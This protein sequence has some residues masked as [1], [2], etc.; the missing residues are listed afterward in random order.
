MMTSYNMARLGRWSNT[1]AGRLVSPFIRI[2][3]H[4]YT[5]AHKRTSFQAP[6]HIVQTEALT[7]RRPV[8][9]KHHIESAQKCSNKTTACKSYK[10]RRPVSWSNTPG[11]RLV[12]LSTYEPFGILSLRILQKNTTHTHTHVYPSIHAVTHIGPTRGGGW[13]VGAQTKTKTSSLAASHMMKLEEE[14]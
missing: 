3:L 7:N 14:D 1:P 12:V 9:C 11:A 5:S 8:F 4:D 6:T 10:M 2:S 13:Q